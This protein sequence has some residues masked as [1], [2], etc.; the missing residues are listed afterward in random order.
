[1]VALYLRRSVESALRQSLTDQLKAV[2]DVEM[3]AL[4]F[5]M[6]EQKAIVSGVARDP[7]VAALAG[8]LVKDSRGVPDDEL[9]AKLDA[10]IAAVAHR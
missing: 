4:H 9:R 6:S 2:L 5:W 3:T 1:M 7:E 8:Q 10:P